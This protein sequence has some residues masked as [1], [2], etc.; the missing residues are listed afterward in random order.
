MKDVVLIWFVVDTNL[1]AGNNVHTL[2]AW[3][4]GLTTDVGHGRDQAQAFRA[5]GLSLPDDFVVCEP[6]ERGLQTPA[7]MTQTPQLPKVNAGGYE[8]EQTCSVAIRLDR[9]PTPG[10]TAF[11][12]ARARSF[13]GW[14]KCS[15][16]DPE[17]E[18]LGFRI[19]KETRT[20]SSEPVEIDEEAVRVASIKVALL[21]RSSEEA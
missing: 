5:A 2:A 10:E 21:K 13:T 8:L 18:V 11:L 19:M 4:T 9:M 20:R 12:I 6:D 17:G 16:N 1:Y 14:R 3:M 7:T 15:P